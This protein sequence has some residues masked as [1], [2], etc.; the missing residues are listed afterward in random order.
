LILAHPGHV[1]AA[2]SAGAIVLRALVLTATAVLAGTAVL[3][4]GSPAASRLQTL[5]AGLAGTGIVLSVVVASA[6]WEVAALQLA[7]TVWVAARPSRPSGSALL[8]LLAAEASAGATAG[9]FVAAFVHTTAASI[10]LGAV[11]LV[12]VAAHRRDVLRELTPVAVVATAA[13]VVSGVVQAWWDRFGLD[14]LVFDRLVLL[15]SALFLFACSLGALA[16]RRRPAEAHQSAPAEGQTHAQPV[17]RRRGKALLWCSSA[18]L[19]ALL[20]AASIGAV[21]VAVPIAPKAAQ[22]LVT[23]AAGLQVTVVPQRPGHNLVHVDSDEPVTVNGVRSTVRPGT[24]GQWVDVQ[25]PQGRSRLRVATAPAQRWVKPTTGSAV[26]DTGTRTGLQVQGA[27]CASAALSSRAPLTSCPEAGL[28]E[29]DAAALKDLVRW[30]KRRGYSG[31]TVQQDGTP[32]S[33]QAAQVLEQARADNQLS[34]TGALVVTGGWDSAAARLASLGRTAPRDGVYLSPWLLNGP[35]LS[36]YAVVGPLVV[37]PFDPKGV[38]ARR[39][40]S[41]V[42]AGET[43]SPAGFTAWGGASDRTAIWATTPASIFPKDLGHG[44]AS[45]GGWFPGGALVAVGA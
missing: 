31:L 25:L 33:Q 7:L 5:M 1:V 14:G 4:P 44:H 9:F 13:V 2:V 28:A 27:E 43:P 11:A 24:T 30:L 40:L 23:R 36:T 37:L 12:A 15:K 38:A 26:V 34:S 16:L 8:V 45:L 41:R 32:R 19:G 29:A 3:R 18:E 35:L 21:L 22:P 17:V 10:W 39:Y 42:P 20:G 6:T